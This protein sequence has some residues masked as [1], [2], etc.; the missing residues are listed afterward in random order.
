[1][2][3]SWLSAKED[4]AR[5]GVAKYIASAWMQRRVCLPTASAGFGSPRP[6]RSTGRFAAAG[7]SIGAVRPRCVLSTTSTSCWAMI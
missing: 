1:M 2:A 7:R 6:A 3:Q 5:F 4:V